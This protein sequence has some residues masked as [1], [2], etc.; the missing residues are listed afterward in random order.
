MLPDFLRSGRVLFERLQLETYGGK[1]EAT[2][3]TPH[4]PP[5]PSA[6]KMVGPRHAHAS[7]PMRCAW[8]RSRAKR[9]ASDRQPVPPASA[10]VGTGR[11]TGLYGPNKEH[12]SGRVQQTSR[13]RT[14]RR[15]SG[16]GR[17]AAP[18]RANVR[19]H[20]AIPSVANGLR[21]DTVS[22]RYQPI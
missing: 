3:P 15:E 14:D 12:G 21:E 17:D 7:K 6:C 10:S 2:S 11:G 20:G 18:E 8:L 22:R 16:C 19:L 5:C 4:V 13:T 1:Q 9:R